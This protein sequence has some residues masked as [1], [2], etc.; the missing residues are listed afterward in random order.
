MSEDIV[1]PG[2]MVDLNKKGISDFLYL[3]LALPRQFLAASSVAARMVACP[4]MVILSPGVLC[5]SRSPPWEEMITLLIPARLISW[6]GMG[7][8]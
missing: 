7:Q 2:N 4:R 6:S 8:G 3:R 5:S 1:L